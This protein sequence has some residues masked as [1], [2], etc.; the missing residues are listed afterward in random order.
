MVSSILSRLFLIV[1]LLNGTLYAAEKSSKAESEKSPPSIPG[2]SELTNE[3]IEILKHIALHGFNFDD[4][5]RLNGP[6]MQV[7]KVLGSDK[8][9]MI[10]QSVG[11]DSAKILEKT[12]HWNDYHK[13]PE[14]KPGFEYLWS[15]VGSFFS[16]RRL[17]ADAEPI[18]KPWTAQE[19]KEYTDPT[20]KFSAVSNEVDRVISQYTENK[21]YVHTILNFALNAHILDALPALTPAIRNLRNAIIEQGPKYKGLVYRGSI[22]SPMEITMMVHKKIFFIPS[23]VSTSMDEDS[24]YWNP[25]SGPDPAGKHNVKFVIDTS[26]F[27]DHSTIIQDHQSPYKEKECL[28]ACYNL[29]EYQRHEYT[30]AD[31]TFRV[32]LKVKNPHN[33]VPQIDEELENDLPNWLRKRPGVDKTYDSRALS[34]HV[35]TYVDSLNRFKK[36]PPIKRQAY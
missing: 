29:Y 23:F 13:D 17:T 25:L 10:A 5:K 18:L 21:N 20:K 28:L 19:R 16:T 32:Y 31:Q 1:F 4:R 27:P 33:Y 8:D 14:L 24:C 30:E 26:E 35:Q 6:A 3:Q 15:T 36:L 11:I 22:A 7:M 12:V 34:Y 2:H 9:T